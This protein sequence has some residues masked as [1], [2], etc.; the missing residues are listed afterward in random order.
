M[1][2]LSELGGGSEEQ[3]RL[4]GFCP[5]FEPLCPEAEEVFAL[6]GG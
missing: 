4:F 2:G 5:A 3:R 1:K 6:R